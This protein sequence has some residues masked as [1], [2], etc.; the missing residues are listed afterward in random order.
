MKKAFK[1]IMVVILVVVLLIAGVIFWVFHSLK[2]ELGDHWKDYANAFTLQTEVS[3]DL[4]PLDNIEQYTVDVQYINK[5]GNVDSRPIRLY[6]PENISQPMPLIYVPHY[7]MAENAAELRRY[8][9]QGW[10]VA[11]PTEVLPSHNGLLTDDDLVFN[12]AALYTLRHMDEFDNQRIA[13]VGGSAGGYTTLMLSALQMGNCASIATAPIANVYFN[14]YQYFQMAQRD[15][16]PFFL[17]LVRDSFTPILD[18]FPDAND[19]ERWEAFSAVG[20]ANCYSS[21]FVITHVTSDILVPIDQ[22]T[23]AF[24]YAHEGDSMP[25][26]FSTR[27][28]EENPGVLGH[29]LVDELPVEL[30]NVEH[31]I[32]DDPNENSGMPYDEEKLFNILIYDDGPTQSYGS[33]RATS[34]TGIIDDVPYLKAMFERG[35]A[36]NEVLT[37]GKLLLLMERYMGE[38]VQLP[39]HEGVDDTVYGSLAVYRQEIVEELACWVSNHSLEELDAAVMEAISSL[40]H[41]QKESKYM[42]AWEEIRNELN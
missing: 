2:T 20:L 39:A 30:T 42:K 8:L 16:A 22:I 40:E 41:E 35:L 9:E 5:V 17:K 19:T 18:N 33:H 4:P 23:R 36:Q 1:V 10:A 14:F 15:D 24:T 7:E 21:P 31:I 32:I 11:S 29:S 27:L 34:G 37:S 25:E 26:G 28:P 13:I 6:V 12:N 38:S 3:K